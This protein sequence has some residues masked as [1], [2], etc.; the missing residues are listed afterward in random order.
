MKL[1]QQIAD[2]NS[3]KSIAPVGID[4]LSIERDARRI[5]GNN[6]IDLQNCVLDNWP[7]CNRY[8]YLTQFILRLNYL[9]EMN[10][11]G[12]LQNLIFAMGGINFMNRIT[13][14]R[15]NQVRS[16]PHH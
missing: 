6:E 11:Y 8:Q 3:T 15:I 1:R 9:N 14:M 5:K 16:L 7:Q 13:D 10:N 2:R 4:M 12:L